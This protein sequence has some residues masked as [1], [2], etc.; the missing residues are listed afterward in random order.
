ML[1]YIYICPYIFINY[2]IVASLDWCCLCLCGRL[3]MAGLYTCVSCAVSKSQCVRWLQ[4]QRPTIVLTKW[5]HWFLV[6]SPIPPTLLSLLLCCQM[7]LEQNIF[8]LIGLWPWAWFLGRICGN[9]PSCDYNATLIVVEQWT[10][11]FKKRT[12]LI[13]LRLEPKVFSGR[14][15]Q[16]FFK[17]QPRISVANR[18]G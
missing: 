2:S 13:F 9:V 8:G 10:V 15:G 16:T 4:D 17:T 5:A 14:T 7:I 11:Y 18:K 1:L 3:Y 6:D 12:R